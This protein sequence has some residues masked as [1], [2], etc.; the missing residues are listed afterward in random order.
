MDRVLL[1]L[2]RQAP[3]VPAMAAHRITAARY[4]ELAGE[5]LA[6]NCEGKIGD[7]HVDRFGVDARVVLSAPHAVRHFGRNGAAKAADAATGGLVRVISEQTQ[8]VAVVA[9]G[10]WTAA[11]A[12]HVVGEPC[13]YREVL[14]DAVATDT[15]LFDVHGMT[16]DHGADICIGTGPFEEL[17]A[18]AVSFTVEVMRGAGLVVAV[19]TPFSAAHPGTVTSWGQRRGLCAF[20]VEVC[21]ALRRPWQSPETAVEFANLLSDVVVGLA[22]AGVAAGIAVKS[23]RCQ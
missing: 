20:Q 16:D 8:L 2:G 23:S 10:G 13:P 18:K 15:V 14:A 4:A 7:R 9:S 5:Y 3:T 1:D 17:S 19:N 22:G 12:N 11:N 6:N 21:S